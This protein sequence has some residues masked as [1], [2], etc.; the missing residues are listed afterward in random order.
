M[1][2]ASVSGCRGKSARRYCR[3]AGGRV[4]IEEALMLDEVQRRRATGTIVYLAQTSSAVEQRI[5]DEWVQ[6]Q[7][8][9]RDDTQAEL[10][11]IPFPEHGQTGPEAALR[12]RLQRGDDPVLAPLR[13]AWLP[14]ERAGTRTARLV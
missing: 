7:H 9:A 13:V 2:A 12:H 11:T 3:T 10:V 4:R 1:A 8:A 6:W 5:L 14:K